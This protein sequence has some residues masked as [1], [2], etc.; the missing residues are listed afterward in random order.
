MPLRRIGDRVGAGKVEM[1]VHNKIV[2]NGGMS[3]KDRAELLTAVDLTT[4]AAMHEAL[5]T[6]PGMRRKVRRLGRR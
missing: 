3:D 2:V 5:N 1:T 6:D 4:R